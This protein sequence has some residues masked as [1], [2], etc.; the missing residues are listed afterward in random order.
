MKTARTPS[1]MLRGVGREN[2]RPAI[3]RGEPSRTRQRKKKLPATLIG[4]PQ[5]DG[6]RRQKQ[7]Q[8]QFPGWMD[9]LRPLVCRWSPH[10]DCAERC[11]WEKHRQSSL[12]NDRD[13]SSPDPS[14]QRLRERG[15]Q[16]RQPNATAPYHHRRCKP[17]CAEGPSVAS[18]TPCL[19]WDRLP[20]SPPP[21]PP[22]PP[23]SPPPHPL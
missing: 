5:L 6:E 22:P 4:D 21:P 23:P 15:F 7:C 19:P 14:D 10:G 2:E 13:R 3:A 12:P 11:R 18:V 16:V 1:K 8:H 20:P 17:H 9:R